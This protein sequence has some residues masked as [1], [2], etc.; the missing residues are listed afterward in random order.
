M[1]KNIRIILVSIF[2]L[3][4]AISMYITTRGSYLEYKEL[5]DK[6][7]SVFNTNVRYQYYI[8]GINFVSTFIIMYF[9]NRG[10]KKGLKVFFDE[11]KKEMPKL[12]NKLI[13][14]VIAVVSSVIVGIIFTPKV[15]L[16]ASN[17]SFEKTDLIF[18][19]DISFYMFVE[20]LIKM[21]LTYIMGIFIFLIIYTIV[22][23]IFVLNRNFDGVDKET[24]KRSYLIKHIIT[25][26]RILSII[27]A[28]YTLVG[29]LD[30]VFSGFITTSSKLQLTGAGLTDITI[31]LWGNIILAIV[32]VVTVFLATANIKKENKSG[33][34]K[35]LLIIPAYMVCMFIVM[36]GFNIIFVNSNKY[37]KEKEYIERNISYTKEAYGINLEDETIEYSGTITT[38]EIKANKSILDNSVII[39][40]KSALDKLN[41]EQAEKGYYTYQTAGIAKYNQDGKN[42]LVYV[43]PREIWTNRRTYNSKTFEYTH[44]YGAILTSAVST[45]EDGDLEYINNNISDTNLI[46]K[47]QIYYGLKTDSIVAVGETNMEEYDYT[48]SKGK[49]HTSSYEGSSGIQLGFLDRFV[50]GIK[51]QNPNLAFSGKIKKNTKILLNRNIIRRAKLVLK[52]VLFDENPYI[53]INDAGEMYWVLD[54]YTASSNYP[55]STYTNIRYNNERNTINYIRNSIKVIINC[56]DGTMNFYITDETDPIAMAYR[57]MYPDVFEELN[58]KIPEDISKNF[59]Y[60]KF[61]YDIQS[62]MI[63]EYHNT[64]SEV[65]Y[66]GDDS[67]KKASYVATQNNKSVTTTLDSYYTMV[68]D[69]NIGLI[70]MYSPNNKQNLTS[71]LVGTNENGTNKLKIYRLSSNE[72]V[73][74][75]TQL[76]SK[77][78]QDENMKNQIEKLNVS[79]VKIS[80]NIMVVPVERTLLYI[81]QIYQTKTNDKEAENPLLKKVIVSSG[82]KVAIGDNLE[83][84]LENIVSQEATSID[85]NTTEDI[86]GTIEAIIKANKNLT[87]SM[88]SKNWEIIGSDIKSLQELID[89]LEVQKKKD[90]EQKKNN[91]NNT[92]NITENKIIENTMN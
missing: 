91:I 23:Y 21:I 55:Y 73:L 24:L 76:D 86:D 32:I 74:G 8:M 87:N 28:I 7:I 4:I 57:K 30:I 70:Q 71:Y 49:E 62:S 43:S 84:A 38:D 13:S 35:N 29:T 10:I 15:I 88:N 14:L 27:Y 72:V 81:E 2:A 18:N 66:R 78:S 37:D 65:L 48:D 16:Y 40:K 58:S 56:Y 3:I 12:V 6:Y 53:A 54:G 82:N 69:D 17:V 44:G 51:N 34:I 36:F 90:D 80:K 83:E 68:K 52:N 50:L 9:S 5:G 1:K 25:N 59:V 33:T 61:L 64:K 75:L 19:L 46:K 39:D 31:K 47:P 11:E 45:T 85:T 77:I 22:Y 67:W 63:E 42:K 92:S 89:K 26:V 79:G 60:P 41:N 20:P